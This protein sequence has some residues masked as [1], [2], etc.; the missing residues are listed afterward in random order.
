[1]STS[2]EIVCCELQTPCFRENKIPRISYKM[3]ESAVANTL[4]MSGFQKFAGDAA[5][6]NRAPRES[7][8][9]PNHKN[10]L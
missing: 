7:D 8:Y 4:L 3:L 2:K 5:L 1:M 9:A 10:A 6:Q